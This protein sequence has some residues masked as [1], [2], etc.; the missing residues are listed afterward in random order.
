M[1]KKTTT[2]RTIILWRLYGVVITMAFLGLLMYHR[3]VRYNDQQEKIALKEEIQKCKTELDKTKTELY[4]VNSENEAINS[5]INDFASEI[6]EL[7]E[8]SMKL[9]EQNKQLVQSNQEYYNELEEFRER[10][11]LYDKYQFAMYHGTQRTDITYDQLR[12]LETL[13][14]DSPICDEDLILAWVMTESGGFETAKNPHSTAKGY[15]QFL[16]STSKFVYSNLLNKDGWTA[17][18]AYDGETN[19]EM[20]VA[21]IDYLYELNNGDLYETIRG[22]RGLRNVASYINKID[23]YLAYNN[24]SIHQIASSN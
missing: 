14:Q 20:M 16:D 18:V 11:E 15:G 12:T 17:N 8:I 10:E 9:D 23:S 5:K 2:K 7:I 13:V 22:Y 21:Y 4:D 6:R 19:L 3:E 1:N 24:K